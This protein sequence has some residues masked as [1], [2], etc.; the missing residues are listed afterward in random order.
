MLDLNRQVTPICPTSSL[1]VLRPAYSQ[2]RARSDKRGCEGRLRSNLSSK[3]PTRRPPKAGLDFS[4][5]VS[6]AVP[7]IDR[8]SNGVGSDV[9]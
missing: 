6:K 8:P 4:C 2:F 1:N 7:N 5:R 3:L 9:D